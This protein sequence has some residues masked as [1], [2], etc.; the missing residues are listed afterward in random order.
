[1]GALAVAAAGIVTALVLLNTPSAASE[2]IPLPGEPGEIAA[3]EEALWVIDQEHSEVLRLDP[4]SGEVDGAPIEVPAE[5]EDVAVSDGVVWV[6]ASDG[7]VASFPEADPSKPEIVGVG[8]EPF[9]IAAFG[10]NVW[11]V[12]PDRG[13][14]IQIDAASAQVVGES[15]VGLN[16]FDVAAGDEGVWVALESGAQE[17]DPE[18]G[19]PDGDPVETP[20]PLE[21]IAVGEGSVWASTNDENAAFLI[22]PE[23]PNDPQRFETAPGP[24]GIVIAAGSAWITGYLTGSV[25]RFDVATGSRIG[26]E[27]AVG[28]TPGGIAATPGAIWVANLEGRSLSRIEP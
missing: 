11:V 2:E 7:S 6:A 24:E 4:E 28:V 1:M 21:S 27:I 22:D 16:P 13:S 8:G 17:I 12:D 3:G 23:Q 18:T 9:G 26:D 10:E 25:D 5:P 20:D 15:E 19:E 14:L